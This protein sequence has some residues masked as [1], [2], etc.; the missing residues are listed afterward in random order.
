VSPIFPKKVTVRI[1][2]AITCTIQCLL[3][4]HQASS[5][6][7]SSTTYCHCDLSS[8]VAEQ[9]M[10]ALQAASEFPNPIGV[11]SNAPEHCPVRRSS[12]LPPLFHAQ[13]HPRA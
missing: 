12:V 7:Q 1:F 9:K 4:A 5:R 13:T 11:P 2:T 10:I 8:G 3:D 6:L